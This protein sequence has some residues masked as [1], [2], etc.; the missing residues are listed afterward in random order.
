MIFYIKCEIASVN[1]FKLF[2]VENVHIRLLFLVTC[3]IIFFFNKLVSVTNVFPPLVFAFLRGS[4]DGIVMVVEFVMI[5]ARD[6]HS[7]ITASLSERV[8]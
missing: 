6:E 1:N 7:I 5:V 2:L 3:K 4:L 8:N